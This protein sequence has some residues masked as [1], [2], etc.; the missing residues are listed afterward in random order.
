MGSRGNGAVAHKAGRMPS[1]LWAWL[2]SPWI[3]RV[4]GL[5]RLLML[6]QSKG[7]QC[8]AGDRGVMGV[9]YNRRI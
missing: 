6:A 5:M 8:A 9:V 3:S 1:L 7:C 2:W 4:M